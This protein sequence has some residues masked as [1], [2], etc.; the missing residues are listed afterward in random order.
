MDLLV[1]E[2]SRTFMF[3]HQN[4]SN[5]PAESVEVA[6]IKESPCKFE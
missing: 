3:V 1:V 6:S 4:V 2:T 5:P